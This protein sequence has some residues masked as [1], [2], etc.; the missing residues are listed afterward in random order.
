MAD[1]EPIDSD[2]A[3]PDTEGA[4]EFAKAFHQAFAAHPRYA[5]AAPHIDALAA[6]VAADRP[7]LDALT[8]LFGRVVSNPKVLQFVVGLIGKIP[9]IGPYADLIAAI[10][11]ALSGGQATTTQ[12]AAGDS[13]PLP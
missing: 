11:A 1:P 6:A 5:A 9:G 2:L 7:L 12:P 10:L 3:A 8:K 4:A 13:G